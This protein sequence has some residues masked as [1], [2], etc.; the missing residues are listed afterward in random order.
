MIFLGLHF[1][2]KHFEIFIEN[3]SRNTKCNFPSLPKPDYFSKLTTSTQPRND[4][5]GIEG[6]FKHLAYPFFSQLTT[7]LSAA[8]YSFHLELSPSLRMYIKLQFSE[9]FSILL[10]TFIPTTI[11]H[12]SFISEQLPT[13]RDN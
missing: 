2:L 11:S 5:I 1:P 7:L 12:H 10:I 3:L 9:L 8:E 13:Y 4:N 6:N